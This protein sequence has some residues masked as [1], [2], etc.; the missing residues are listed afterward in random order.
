MT[1]DLAKNPMKVDTT[2]TTLSRF[3]SGSLTVR[4]VIW[5]GGTNAHVLVLTIN[6]VAMSFT[7]ADA[8]EGTIKY[9]FDQPLGRVD[10]FA[11]TTLPSGTVYIF[12]D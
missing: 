8:L 5:V 6:G 4:E 1:N 11:V 10:S 9:V 3:G 12:L 2:A 7:K